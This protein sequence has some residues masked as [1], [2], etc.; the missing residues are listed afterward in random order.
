M[1]VT[2]QQALALF[3][4]MVNEKHPPHQMNAAHNRTRGNINKMT[5]NKSKAGR[6]GFGRGGRGPTKTRTD[7]RTITLT[8]GTQIEYHASFNFPRNVYLQI[9]AASRLP[10]PFRGLV[11]TMLGIPLLNL[12]AISEHRNI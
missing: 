10:T 1:A 4:N 9:K 6:G 2:Y 3:R 8:D 5:S 12:L 11:E 7:S